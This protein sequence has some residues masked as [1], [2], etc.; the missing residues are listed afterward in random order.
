MKHGLAAGLAAGLLIAAAGETPAKT[1]TICGQKV[2]YTVQPP[3]PDVP[4]ALRAFSGIWVGDAGSVVE[5]YDG[6]F[7][8]GL[9]VE[10]VNPDGTV[11]AKYVWGD[12]VKLHLGL[13]YDIKPG[14]V[15]WPGKIAGGALVLQ[16]PDRA[17]SYEL[18]VAG[19]DEL[20]GRRV[21]PDGRN[22]VALKRG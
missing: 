6:R 18:R 16:T 17:Y 4:A 9:I 8:V 7:C 11:A 1:A 19:R 10:Q 14:V 21:G 13:N 22:V 2:D 12:K 15:D 5:V 3:G 20:K